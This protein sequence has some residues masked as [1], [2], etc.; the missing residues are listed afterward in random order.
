MTKIE[1]KSDMFIIGP[2]T[3]KYKDN[4]NVKYCQCQI[5]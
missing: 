4:S 3:V 2:Q 5:A 1:I